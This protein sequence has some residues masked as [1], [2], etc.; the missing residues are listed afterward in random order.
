[1]HDDYYRYPEHSVVD[2]VLV[3]SIHIAILLIVVPFLAISIFDPV[4]TTTCPRP[5]PSPCELAT[6]LQGTINL[7][8]HVQ[9][10]WK[11]VI[12]LV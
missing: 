1:M 2:A 11:F 9:Y 3:S 8:S 4:V 6:K 10:H 7:N 12:V 5:L